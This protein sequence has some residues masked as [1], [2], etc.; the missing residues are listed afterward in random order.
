MNK[1]VEVAETYLGVYGEGLKELV[2]YYNEHCLPLVEPTRK[3][4]MNVGESWC[5]MFTSVV[6]HKAGFNADEFPFEVSVYFQ[7]MVALERGIFSNSYGDSEVGDLVIYDWLGLGGCDHVGII[8]NKE[9]GV[10]TVIEGNY[11]NTVKYRTVKATSRAIKGYV[12]L[13]IGNVG[14]EATRLENLVKLVLGGFL[15]DGS[16]RVKALGADY[17]KV[18]DMVNKILEG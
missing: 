6:A 5:A 2:D 8:T 3:Y 15:G 14:V 13:S 17:Y 10:L 1:L 9:D 4:K 11:S 18:Q 7:Y 16:E 12:R